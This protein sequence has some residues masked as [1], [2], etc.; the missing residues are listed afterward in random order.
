MLTLLFLSLCCPLL[1]VSL[2]VQRRF[3][4]RHHEKV[5]A[6]VSSVTL[7]SLLAFWDRHIA[8]D[9]PE[10]RKMSFQYS[11]HA[12]KLPERLER[13]TAEAAAYANEKVVLRSKPDATAAPAVTTPAAADGPA[14]AAPATE[15]EDVFL[16]PVV[17]D[18]RP[19]TYV[20]DLL[21]FKNS[22]MLF[23]AGY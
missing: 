16:P 17:L 2:R 20:D 7:E 11:S 4:F 3:D 18:P 19:I 15:A 21:S 6:A 14:S 5:A 1:S 10:R 9:G 12:H 22:C 23:P 13:E 8:M